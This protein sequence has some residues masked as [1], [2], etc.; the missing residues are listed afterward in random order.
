MI[1]QSTKVP[2]LC[3]LNLHSLWPHGQIYPSLAGKGEWWY[4]EQRIC[5]R[6]GF[7]KID[8]GH[9]VIETGKAD[10]GHTWGTGQGTRDSRFPK[11][12]RAEEQ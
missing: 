9:G 10:A 5:R 11:K 6:C 3:R 7:W 8:W 1:P 4:S 2:I 12:A